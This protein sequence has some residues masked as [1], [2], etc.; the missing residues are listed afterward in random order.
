M[1]YL[2][3]NAASIPTLKN[4]FKDKSYLG[5]VTKRSVA[6]SSRSLPGDSDA[7]RV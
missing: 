2:S 7:N 3:G 1:R 5:Y 6:D 4:I